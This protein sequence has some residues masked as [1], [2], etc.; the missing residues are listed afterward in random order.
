MKPTALFV[1]LAAATLLRMSVAHETAFER[2]L[3]NRGMD[4]RSKARKIF[5]EVHT[6]P[7]KNFKPAQVFLCR[8]SATWFRNHMT[9]QMGHKAKAM[10]IAM[11]TQYR[12]SLK[13]TRQADA[14]HLNKK[15]RWVDVKGADYNGFA[16]LMDLRHRF[17]IHNDNNVAVT[18]NVKGGY[19]DETK[20]RKIL[21]DASGM[22]YTDQRVTIPPHDSVWYKDDWGR[23]ANR[24]D[25]FCSMSPMM[26]LPYASW[27]RARF[28]VPQYTLNKKVFPCKATLMYDEE[29]YTRFLETHFENRKKMCLYEPG[30]TLPSSIKNKVS[31]VW[32]CKPNLALSIGYCPQ[33]HLWQ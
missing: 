20:K 12:D 1:L 5:H 6:D 2:M 31:A 30:E 21:V 28:H 10:V 24:P 15:C 7:G 32:S 11:C 26:T 25:G 14:Q 22:W 18:Y 4:W 17:S 33:P 8:P 16:I 3:K 29:H 19:K 23:L 27:H 13:Q 9:T